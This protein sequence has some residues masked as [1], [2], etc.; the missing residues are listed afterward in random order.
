[1]YGRIWHFHL[2]LDPLDCPFVPFLWLIEQKGQQHLQG[3][4]EVQL[5]NGPMAR[6]LRNLLVSSSRAA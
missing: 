1:L 6:S 3:L 5:M 4:S 2:K